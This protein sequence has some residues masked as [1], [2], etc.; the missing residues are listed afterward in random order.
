MPVVALTRGEVSLPY[1]EKHLSHRL[2]LDHLM[3][4]RPHRQT[5]LREHLRLVVVIPLQ[6]PPQIRQRFL[7]CGREEPHATCEEPLEEA[8]VTYPHGWY[9][10]NDQVSSLKTRG[11]PAIVDAFNDSGLLGHAPR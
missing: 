11:Y 7:L 4:E 10:Q 9:Q 8:P 2:A 5:R 3:G 1:G 6:E